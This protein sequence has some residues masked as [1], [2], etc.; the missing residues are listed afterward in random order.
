MPIAK[1]A[2]PHRL[3]ICTLQ[4]TTALVPDNP[5]NNNKGILA[6]V[7]FKKLVP[8]AARDAYMKDASAGMLAST[9][10]GL[11]VPF[12]P[13]VAR[14]L[15][16]AS[17]F[18]ISIITMA[19]V[20]GYIL[21]IVAAHAAEG[22]AKKPIVV[23]TN[24]F[25]SSL[26]MLMMFAT[27]SAVFVTIIAAFWILLTISG[28][29]YSAVMK[30]IYPSAS[31]AKII[32]YVRIGMVLVGIIITAIAG[33]LLKHVDY[34]YVF[35]VAALFG[36]GSAVCFSMIKATERSG[37]S[38][39]P[40]PLFLRN[41]IS[42]L[43]QNPGYGWFCLGIFIS[44]GANFM[45]MPIYVLYQ[46]DV[47][48]VDMVWASWYT[49]V[50]QVTAVF[51]YAFWGHFIDRK[52]P[53]LA[54]AIISLFFAFVP[55]VYCVA[56]HAWM[57]MPVFVLLGIINA[58]YELAYLSG[59]L[60]YAPA[61]KVTSYQAVFLSLMGLRGLTFPF[62]G[63]YIFQHHYLSMRNI[64]LLCSV[65]MLFSVWVQY[66]GHRRYPTLTRDI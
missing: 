47:L 57:L 29:A 59:V 56:T 1:H 3:Q 32:G 17:A 43:H 31:R 53:T 65:M 55:L 19:P 10:S 35:S 14:Q 7:I 50:A 66:E 15:L 52:S 13:I 28:P 62:L 22:K 36:I 54:V 4:G 18:Q 9:M 39:V 6:N 37:E 20:A 38:S 40:L 42:V 24:I 60:S 11:T 25:A 49:I 2:T 23:W 16:H 63:S 5:S 41:A 8:L 34:R 46:V 61:D 48:H 45:A 51:A 44:G 21:S 33:P 58:G 26:L 27:T 64:F 12:F 30:E